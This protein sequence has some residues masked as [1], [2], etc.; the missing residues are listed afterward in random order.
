MT[1]RFRTPALLAAVAL[2]GAA[3]AACDSGSDRGQSIYQ[4]DQTSGERIADPTLTAVAAQP[5]Q[6]TISGKAVAGF[7]P[8]VLT[9]S[10]FVEGKTYVY[11]NGVRVPILSM[12]PTQ[13]TVKAPNM[14]MDDL[15]VKVSVIGAVNFSTVQK[16][17][18]TTALERWGNFGPT[19]TG[20]GVATDYGNSIG[21]VSTTEGGASLGIERVSGVARAASIATGNFTWPELAFTGGF[22]YGVRGVRAVFRWQPGNNTQTVWTNTNDFAAAVQ[23]TALDIES[24]G[25]IWTGGAFTG[26]TEAD[27]LLYK[28]SPTTPTRTTT[29]YPFGGTV[30]A[31]EAT[32]SAIYVAGTVGTAVGVWKYTRS[33]TAL[34][35]PVLFVSVPSTLIVNALVATAD[36]GLLLGVSPVDA[37]A[38]TTFADPLL[39]VT[40]AGVLAP[41]L[42]GLLSKGIVGMRWLDSTHLLVTGAAIVG[43]ANSQKPLVGDLLVV[44]PLLTAMP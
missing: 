36:G 13:I 41:R 22:V 3:L 16:V 40:S 24:D 6:P 37:T 42:Q 23:L 8:L 26:G 27:R 35:A 38:N 31:V 7:T 29:K 12:T 11:F 18:L 44:N 20:L 19:N 14:V 10:G 4:P 2:S 39:Y 32:P 30:T 33:G 17:S 34:S 9:G 1:L 15:S 21:Y 25:T 28:V 43:D 5:G